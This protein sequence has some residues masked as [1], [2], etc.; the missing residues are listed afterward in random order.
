MLNKLDTGT[1]RRRSNSNNEEFETV[2]VRSSPLI[3]FAIKTYS[4]QAIASSGNQAENPLNELAAIQY[5]GSMDYVMAQHECCHDRSFLYSIMEF[6]DGGELFE[7][8]VMNGKKDELQSRIIFSQIVKGVLNLH[9]KGIAHRDLSLENILISRRSGIIKIIDLGMCLKVPFDTNSNSYMLVHRQGTCGKINYM[10]PEIFA[11]DS[12]FD[13]FSCDIWA[14]GIILFILLTGIPL[15]ESPS[16]MDMRYVEVVSGRIGA[17]VA[18]WGIHISLD[19]LDL[20]QSILKANPRERPS[21]QQIISHR[22]LHP[23]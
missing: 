22:W 13:P 7:E 23:A 3:E 18:K 15:L 10:A 19:A 6:M 9:S 17:L 8:I 11:N 4:R 20:I 21:L 12:P 5:I 14:L 16:P 1:T 2:Y